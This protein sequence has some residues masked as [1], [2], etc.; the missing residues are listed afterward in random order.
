M[1]LC[2]AA[3]DHLGY[4]FSS[5]EG[6]VCVFP[7][8]QFLIYLFIFFFFWWNLPTSVG[9]GLRGS[10]LQVGVGDLHPVV[11]K[12][13]RVF[14]ACV[15]RNPPRG[16]A[17]THVLCGAQP[18]PILT[19]SSDPAR[20]GP[21][22]RGGIPTKTPLACSQFSGRLLSLWRVPLHVLRI[23]RSG[24]AFWPYLFLLVRILS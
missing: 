21:L 1:E 6:G 19:G 16:N 12:G 23:R 5:F 7:G 15:R 11:S 10:P 4:V 14:L 22:L 3:Y 9:H 13:I 20:G 18:I 24:R 2:H 17:F 8:V